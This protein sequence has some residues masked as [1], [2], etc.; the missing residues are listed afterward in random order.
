LIISEEERASVMQYLQ[1]AERETPVVR[2]GPSALKFLKV[3]QDARVN[4]PAAA[5]VSIPRS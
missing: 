3:G 5:P 4:P 2:E 1:D